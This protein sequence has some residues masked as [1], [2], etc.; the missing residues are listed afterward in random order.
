MPAQ[1]ARFHEPL[2]EFATMNPGTKRTLIV[3]L[4]V[5]LC[6]CLSAVVVCKEYLSGKEWPE[7]A[8]VDP[9]LVG[10]PP[11]DAVVLFDGKDMSQ[12]NGGEKW[13]V[14]DGY[15]ISHG[16]SITTKQNFGDCQLHVEWA[17]PEKVEG[18]GQGRGN[19]GVFMLNAYEI[20]I[21]DSYHN[22]TYYDGQCAA[23]YKQWPPMVNACR[24][25]GQWQT[26]DILFTSPQFDAQGKLLKPAYVTVLQNG[27]VVQNHTEIL[28]DSSWDSPPKYTP[29][30]PKGPIQLQFHVNPVRFRNIWVRE[31]HQQKPIRVGEPNIK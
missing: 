19:S 25:P 17:A 31:I 2:Q 26:Y 8:V 16:T 14:Q 5:V 28:G 15:A 29:R 20:Q 22:K 7:P 23:I 9:G 11:A 4:A 18:D 12:W 27:V 10:G 13:I 6:G 3:A 24:K 30:P 1:E 21:L